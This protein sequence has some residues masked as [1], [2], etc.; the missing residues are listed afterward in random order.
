MYYIN[1][2]LNPEIFQGK[3]KTK[4]YFEGWYFKLIDQYEQKV[5]AIILQ[6]LL[7]HVLS[8]HRHYKK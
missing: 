4:K 7:H 6:E 3:Y 5:F 2:T 8:L 1:K